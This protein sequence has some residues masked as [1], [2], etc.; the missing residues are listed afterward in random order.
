VSTHEVRVVRINEIEKHPN[1]DRLGLVRIDGFVAII[2]LEDFKVGDLAA[3]IE[4]DYVVPDAQQYEFLKGNLRIKSRRFR[5][6]W[7]QG[8]L[9]K[10]PAGAREGD[11]VMEQMGIVR[12]EP[13]IRGE[14]RGGPGG[15]LGFNGE[16]KR[17][18]QELRDLPIYDL[19]NWRKHHKLF[20]PGEQVYVTEKIHGANARYAFRDGKIWCGS[21]KTWKKAGKAV[22]R[23]EKLVDALRAALMWVVFN[24]IPSFAISPVFAFANSVWKDRRRLANIWWTALTPEMLEFCEAH[25]TWVLY[26][27]VYGDVQDLKYGARA[28]EVWF[29]AFDIMT[30]EGWMPAGLFYAM[31]HDFGIPTAPLV[32]VGPYDAAELE[33]LSHMP[34]TQ[35]SSLAGHIG[36]G[37][38]IKP[39]FERSAHIG[40]VALKLV[41]DSYLARAV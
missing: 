12:Y 1:A 21:R 6:V 9:T 32:Y 13:P 24:A 33:E 3:Y 19:E 11:N 41:S 31:C 35:V 38:V 36:E 39:A 40:R 34:T 16:A 7:S 17:V 14:H 26:G 28:G 27:E 25:P 23:L 22:T 8:L 18:P 20:Q 5:G 2:G 37:I 4:P 10:A 30:P 15:K 29:R